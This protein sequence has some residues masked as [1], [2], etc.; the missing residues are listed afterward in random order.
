MKA[1][2]PRYVSGAK[3]SSDSA[4]ITFMGR[5]E[6]MFEILT[7]LLISMGDCVNM[8]AGNQQGALVSNKAAMVCFL[9]ELNQI[10]LGMAA[11]AV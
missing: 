7:L 8:S 10:M 5:A 1:N 9:C 3:A 2:E 6:K 11:I 4:C